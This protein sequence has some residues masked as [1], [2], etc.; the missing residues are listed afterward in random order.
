[1]NT[2]RK[3]TAIMLGL[4]AGSL[5]A[6]EVTVPNTFT[7]GARAVAAEVNENFTAVADAVNDNDSRIETNEMAIT[8]NSDAI[9]QL[10]MTNGVA[11]TPTSNTSVTLDASDR[12]VKT[13]I[14][15]APVDGHAQYTFAAWFNCDSG[16][17][18]CLVRCSA[19]PDRASIDTSR[20]TIQTVPAGG[21]GS[22]SY[23]FA[24]AVTAGDNGMNMVC[25]TF[26][27]NGALG[28]A[29]LTANYSANDYSATQ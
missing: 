20:F 12:I 16:S 23:T 13:L 10:S 18:T 3:L 14:L 27:G 7:S 19:G 26:R 22:L 2:D 8:A 4:V 25:D 17:E 29:T 1:M 15:S 24:N 9:S 21:Y 11:Y 28:D 6:A 5:Q